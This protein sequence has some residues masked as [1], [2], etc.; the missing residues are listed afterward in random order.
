MSLP[1]PDGYPS[2]GEWVFTN[3]DRATQFYPTLDSILVV[4]EN[5]DALSNMSAEVVD[6]AGTAV[7]QEEDECLLTFQGGRI[8]AGHL[9]LVEEDARSEV[10][11]RMYR[12]SG[13]DYTAK[14]DDSLVRRRV[15]RKKEN[16]RRRVKW[17]LN[18]LNW[19]LAGRDLSGL[20]SITTKV[21]AYDYFGMSVREALQ[22]VAD[23]LRLHFYI[24]YDNVFHMFR[25]EAV[26]APFGLDNEAP[27]FAT[28]FPLREW[29]YAKDSQNLANA[30]L[31]EPEKRKHS[32]WETD[33]TS[34]AAYERQ[35]RFISDTNLRGRQQASNT[36]LRGLAMTADPEVEG[37][38]VVHEPGLQAGMTVH[39]REKLWD[40]DFDRFIRGVEIRASDPEDED[41][42]S[43]LH[44]T[45][46]L[47]DRRKPTIGGG[48]GGSGPD[49]SINRNTRPRP[50]Q[51]DDVGP[52][53]VDDFE[54]DVQPPSMAD[55]DT[56]VAGSL[57]YSGQA[58]EGVS[59]FGVDIPFSFGG[60]PT[61]KRAASYLGSWYR[62]WT[63]RTADSM[64]AGLDNQ[65][66][67][68]L[69]L[70]QWWVFTVDTHP[71]DPAGIKVT[72]PVPT[73]PQ[74]YAGAAAAKFEWVASA[75][76]PGALR[77]GEPFAEVQA[78]GSAVDGVVPYEL[79]PADGQPLYIGL[80]TKWQATHDDW[81]CGWVWPFMSPE[82][83]YSVVNGDPWSGYSG[84]ATANA[85]SA[86]IWQVWDAASSDFGSTLDV[87]K[88]P[89]D[90]GHPYQQPAFEGSPTWEVDGEALVVTSTAPA[91]VGITVLG[92][93]EDPAEPAGVWSDVAWATELMFELDAAGDV[94]Q[95]GTR[96]LA[97]T[98][99]GEGESVVGT[100]H[101]GDSS[102]AQGISVAGPSGRDYLAIPMTTGERWLAKFDTR[103]GYEV[104]GKL[105]R[106]AD[107]EPALWH[108]RI[109]MAETEDDA[110]RWTL[111]TRVG[112]VTGE[113][114]AKVHR[115]RALGPARAGTRVVREFLGFADGATN[116]FETSHQFREDSLRLMVNGIHAGPNDTDGAL[117]R[118]RLDFYPTARS[119]MRA[120]YVAD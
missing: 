32:T 26:P 56:I 30:I 75:S 44:S 19:T 39:I 120:T 96:E 89:F 85:P 116:V 82:G 47:S 58:S 112:N 4:Q 16:V 10:G 84:R 33:A 78:G 97:L 66:T 95:S 48:P 55:G 8:W 45:L 94:G 67:G 102:Y 101:F 52:Y 50:G 109:P 37:T 29:R 63:Q 43:M 87:A 57:T 62:N 79:V 1:V 69:Q 14:L 103:N 110:D 81:T 3:V 2:R 99:I 88:A 25:A 42:E 13:Q 91:G 61:I 106:R 71:A 59:H 7:F 35:E 27:D 54:R 107:K 5:P 36:A 111:W 114:T 100:V 104:R 72:L 65:F 28:T 24:D 92:G 11:P 34:I 21:E 113:Q 20:A 83:I 76:P 53:P 80:R 70:E 74:G 77:D 38:C 46:I 60:N 17:L 86:A 22:H 73:Q 49:D 98:T 23:E 15:K 105:W 115:I 18:H 93:R 12:L 64:C 9:K 117:T 90:G 40:H 51:V 31:A 118:A 68:W 6:E 108:V 41:A 119:L